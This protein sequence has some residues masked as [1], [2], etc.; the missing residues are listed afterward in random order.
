MG[1]PAQTLMARE[2]I[3]AGL[4]GPSSI[5]AFIFSARSS[6]NMSQSGSAHYPTSKNTCIGAQTCMLSHLRC[7]HE[8]ETQHP[9]MWDSKTWCSAQTWRGT[10][11]RP[12]TTIGSAWQ[13]LVLEAWS[14][15][16][17]QDMGLHQMTLGGIHSRTQ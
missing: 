17:P 16:M 4:I 5:R 12:E 7:W 14:P 6:I 2:P 3:R 15:D 9:C 8:G 11:P 10:L 13:W 1:W